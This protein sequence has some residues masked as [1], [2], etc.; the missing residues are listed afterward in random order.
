MT[1]NGI[2]VFSVAG[3]DTTSPDELDMAGSVDSINSSL[4]HRGRRLV[5]L[6]VRDETRGME[7]YN[8]S[9]MQAIDPT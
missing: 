8:M 6:D 9:H 3:E 5:N 4:D 1:S 2:P 7:I